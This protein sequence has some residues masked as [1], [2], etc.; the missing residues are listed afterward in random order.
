MWWYTLWDGSSSPSFGLVGPTLSSTPDFSLSCVDGSS[1]AS[2]SV[3]ASSTVTVS[4]S[5]ATFSPSH[6]DAM[7]ESTAESI[8]GTATSAVVAIS[9]TKSTPTPVAASS[10][11]ASSSMSV[12]PVAETSLPAATGSPS[13]TTVS[14]G[15][16]VPASIPSATSGTCP[17]N[18]SG[19][20]QY[21]HLIVPVDASSPDTVYGTSY[22]GKVSSTESTVFNFDIP[23]SYSEKT[24]SLVFLFPTKAELGTA[25]YTTTGS[26]GLDFKQLSS[27]ATEQTSYNSLPS[28][29]K[30]TG[31]VQKLVAGNSYVITTGPCA[32]G[33]RISY[34]ASATGNLALD[35]FQDSD[36][37]PLGLFMTVC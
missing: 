23:E 31:S 29:S 8:F 7:V 26:G 14:Q 35:F 2:S 22:N 16:A 12:G 24:C 17:T 25:D 32:A 6:T 20:Y 36:P 33:E 18:L 30:D 15:T 11:A 1:G 10:A 4:A 34:E 21:P 9:A 27:A 5:A 19:P 28:I 3:A 37:S 13:G